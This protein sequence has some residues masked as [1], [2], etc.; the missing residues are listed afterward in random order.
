MRCRWPKKTPNILDFLR[1][2]QSKSITDGRLQ[3]EAT[4]D[5]ELAIIQRRGNDWDDYKNRN[6]SRDA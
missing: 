6:I 4:T 2:D 1:S 3:Q 5:D